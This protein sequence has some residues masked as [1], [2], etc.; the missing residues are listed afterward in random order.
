MPLRNF[1]LSFSRRGTRTN[2]GVTWHPSSKHGT[3]LAGLL[4]VIVLLAFILAGW[5]HNFLA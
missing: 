5:L 4:L 3:V 2:A 1:G